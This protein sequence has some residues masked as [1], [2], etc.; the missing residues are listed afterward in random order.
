M[1]TFNH[2]AQSRSEWASTDQLTAMRAIQPSSEGGSR[3][4][5]PSEERVKL[6]NI[7]SG[8]VSSGVG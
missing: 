1:T 6:E 5:E 7:R 8:G 3:L 4:S 2:D